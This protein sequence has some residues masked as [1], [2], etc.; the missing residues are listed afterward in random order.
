[1]R[2]QL[3]EDDGWIKSL[4]DEYSQ[5]ALY[6]KM[7][8]YYSIL[9]KSKKDRIHGMRMS[10]P[11][12][13]Q[14]YNLEMLIDQMVKTDKRNLTGVRTSLEMMLYNQ[15]Y[16]DEQW[17]TVLI[18]HGETALEKAKQYLHEKIIADLPKDC[19]LKEM[20]NWWTV[21]YSEWYSW[22]YNDAVKKITE[23]HLDEVFQWFYYC[24]E[25]TYKIE[26]EERRQ[27][28]VDRTWKVLIPWRHNDIRS[29]DENTYKI[30]NEEEKRQLV[31]RML[32]ALIW[33]KFDKLHL[34]KT[35]EDWKLE[36][37]WRKKEEKLLEI[38]EYDHMHWLLERIKTNITLLNVLEKNKPSERLKTYLTEKS[39]NQVYRKFQ[40]QW[41][42][43]P[44]PLVKAHNWWLQK[45]PEQYIG[46]LQA[47]KPQTWLVQSV[48]DRF[49]PWERSYEWWWGSWHWWFGKWGAM[50]MR[51]N[52]EFESFWWEQLQNNLSFEHQLPWNAVTRISG[53]YQWWKRCALHHWYTKQM[54]IIAWEEKKNRGVLTE[55]GV[56]AW[57]NIVLPITINQTH[58][59]QAYALI[60]WNKTPLELD[61]KANWITTVIVP[62]WANSIERKIQQW[63]PTWLIPQITTEQ[64]KQFRKHYI[65]EYGTDCTFDAYELLPETAMFLDAIKHISPRDQLIMCEQYVRDMMWYDEENSNSNQ[66]SWQPLDVQVQMCASHRVDLLE[67]F[68]AV[69]NKL[70]VWVCEDAS[71]LLRIML[72]K[73]WFMSWKI[74]W[75]AWWVGHSWNFVI[76]PGEKW[77]IHMIELDW[78][79]SN[80]ANY[81]PE[82]IQ[83]REERIREMIENAQRDG[84][85]IET[86]TN[87]FEST[88]LI[89]IQ[90]KKTP[91]GVFCYFG[92][93]DGDVCMMNAWWTR[94]SS[95]WAENYAVT[96]GVSSRTK[97]EAERDRGKWRGN[98]EEW[99]S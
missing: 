37:I 66:K 82:S 33:W 21:T 35:T 43:T 18:T 74:N 69:A 55:V 9:L 80:Y 91:R 60:A 98:R 88:E 29:Y 38:Y 27:Q 23:T 64:Y 81:Q 15:E 13:E 95:D 85:K 57:E 2:I 12:S 50:D 10:Y 89:L 56:Y 11:W 24:D 62:E 78:T 5:W 7:V 99:F 3:N 17:N 39:P 97:R 25:N 28:L 8:R 1:M 30:K 52:N 75:I 20:E 51:D 14:E 22:K 31:D 45:N 41:W 65:A 84:K 72:R 83:E 6:E 36:F 49:A 76:I 63:I 34:N 47:K 94:G 19:E 71:H 42:S 79:P 59:I 73:L 61:T 58:I 53:S 68:P 86:T 93:A 77:T 4:F 26:N 46:L 16:R 54:S 44:D 96:W 32:I 92:T 40:S 90:Q 70:Y 87:T 48:I 67:E